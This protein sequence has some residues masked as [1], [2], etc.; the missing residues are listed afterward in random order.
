MMIKKSIA[1]IICRVQ[2]RSVNS[3][4]ILHL[5]PSIRRLFFIAPEV[6]KQALPVRRRNTL[7]KDTEM[8]WC[9]AEAVAVVAA[10]V[11]SPQIF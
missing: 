4:Q 5:Y 9:S 11:V 10:A 7:N 6:R 8:Q 1:K 2:F 3:S